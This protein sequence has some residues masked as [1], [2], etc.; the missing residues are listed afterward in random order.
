MKQN[1]IY[2]YLFVVFH[3]RLERR[4]PCRRLQTSPRFDE[5]R[6]DE[7]L[8]R[9]SYLRRS[10]EQ[11]TDREGSRFTLAS[12]GRKVKEGRP[13]EDHRRT[14]GGPSDDRR[15]TVGRPS[16]ANSS[17]N[18]RDER[19]PERAQF[20]IWIHCTDRNAPKGWMLYG[21]KRRCV[22]DAKY[23]YTYI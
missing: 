16:D 2:I 14:I 11:T 13:S 12:A 15:T 19:S 5:S 4:E 1:G 21:T 17:Q 6:E 20:S 8:F 7:K 23:T 9:N 18:R 3:H 10:L 22:D